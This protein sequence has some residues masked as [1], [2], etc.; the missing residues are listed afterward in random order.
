MSRHPATF[1]RYRAFSTATL[2]SLCNDTLYFAH[3]GTFNDPMDCKPSLDCDSNPEQLRALLAFLVRRRVFAEVLE[4]LRKVRLKGENATAH[5]D[6]RAQSEADREL[7]NIEYHATNPEYCVSEIEAEESLL[8]HEIERELLRY[9]ERGVCCFSTT[10]S[11]PLLWS[12]Y[13]DQHQGLCVGYGLDRNPKPSLHK[14]IYGGNRTIK[15]STLFRAFI[16]DEHEALDELDRNVLLRKAR[17]WSYEREWRLIG[18]QGLKDSPLLLK[19]VTFGLRCSQSVI[20]SVVQALTGR[21]NH[22]R[23]YEMHEDRS[24]FVLQREP[25]DLEEL[26]RHYPRTAISVI[27]M[28][29]GPI[30]DDE[31]AL[32]SIRGAIKI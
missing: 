21:S 4:S 14:V 17:G 5:A 9:Y 1:Y 3:P 15:T 19:E 11:S 13:G 25:L 7:A 22:V 20:H 18:A 16:H 26:N 30:D 28:G 31:N 32:S 6:R 23:F 29:F 27:E 8:T 24:R 2:D 10:Y 12:H